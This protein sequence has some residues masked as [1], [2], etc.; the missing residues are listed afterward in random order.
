MT[1]PDF[2]TMSKDEVIAWFRTTDDV[3]PVL[4]S[5][6]PATDVVSRPS[7]DESQ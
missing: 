1:G 7:N 3:S 5:M 2:E 4:T 6:T